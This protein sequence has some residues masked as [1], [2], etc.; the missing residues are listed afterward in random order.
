MS[1]LLAGLALRE[2]A[3]V[4]LRISRGSKTGGDHVR[5][6]QPDVSRRLPEE[7]SMGGKHDEVRGLNKGECAERFLELR[8]G[9]LEHWSVDPNT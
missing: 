2:G 6:L 7:I 8:D 5:P 4:T 3:D 9:T 1:S